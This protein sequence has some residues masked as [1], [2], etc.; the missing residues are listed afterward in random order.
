MKA[1]ARLF[2]REIVEKVYLNGM[3]IAQGCDQAVD[4]VMESLN[5]L[6]PG[7]TMKGNLKDMDTVS[8]ELV[9]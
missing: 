3:K 6:D 4:E 1:T 8:S 7:W 5:A 2:A 9:R